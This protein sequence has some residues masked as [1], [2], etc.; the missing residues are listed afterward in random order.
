MSNFLATL[1]GIL[2]GSIGTYF[3]L[4]KTDAAP[5]E[6]FQKKQKQRQEE[7]AAS[8]V[9]RSVLTVSA[10]GREGLLTGILAQLW[11]NINVAACQIIRESVEPSLAESL[12]KPFSTF[13][14]TKLDLGKTP[15]RFANRPD[16]KLPKL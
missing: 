1:G 8:S 12:P 14:F 2:V 15:I 6:S 5:V 4:K 16:R 7:E 3:L 9:D 13:K 11:P 10:S